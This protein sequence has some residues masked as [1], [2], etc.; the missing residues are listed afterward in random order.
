MLISSIEYQVSNCQVSSIKY[1]VA[2]I[3]YQDQNDNSEL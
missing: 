1:Q 2:S 3:K